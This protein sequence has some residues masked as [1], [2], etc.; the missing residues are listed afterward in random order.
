MGLLDRFFGRRKEAGHGERKTPLSLQL[1]FPGRLRLGA[2]GLTCAMRGVHPSLADARCEE[3]PRGEAL[4]SPLVQVTWKE[5]RVE[6][7][8]IETP[9]P[10][11]V[12]ERATAGD[13]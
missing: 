1:L 4:G 3:D 6:V 13:V 8:G 12:V 11:E 2:P 7:V 5:H 9:M 10:S